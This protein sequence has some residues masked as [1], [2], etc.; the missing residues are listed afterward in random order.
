MEVPQLCGEA[1]A[2]CKGLVKFAFFGRQ[3]RPEAGL[4]AAIQ[5]K[6]GMSP[7]LEPNLASANVFASF[8]SVC[9]R[10]G[11]RA[12]ASEPASRSSS[13]TAVASTLVKKQPLTAFSPPV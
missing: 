4:Q 7:P 11:S 5:A 2:Q 10:S 8:E 1:R 3:A 6:E 9:D 12:A 13:V